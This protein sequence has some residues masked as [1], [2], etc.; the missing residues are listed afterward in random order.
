ASHP[1]RPPTPSG[2]PTSDAAAP[3]NPAP[4]AASFPRRSATANASCCPSCTCGGCAP[5]TSSPTHWATSAAPPS[6]T[7]SAKPGP[8]RNKTAAPPPRRPSVTAPPP[9]S[10]PP[11]QPAATHQQLD[12]LRLHKLRNVADRLPHRHALVVDKRVGAPYRNPDPLVAQAD[13]EALAR[14]LHR[15]HPGAAASLR[16]GLAE[17]LTIARLSVPATLPGT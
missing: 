7:P 12:S 17:A 15:S 5:S 13:L 16:E 4:E 3:A 2:A 9:N 1:G 8:S 14:E 11:Q 10:S 6:A